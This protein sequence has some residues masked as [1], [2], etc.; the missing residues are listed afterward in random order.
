MA[1]LI[2]FC[3]YSGPWHI[4]NPTIIQGYSL[5]QPYDLRELKDFASLTPCSKPEVEASG[6]DLDAGEHLR[7]LIVLTWGIALDN[8]V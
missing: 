3:A 5:A 1:G 4:P 8:G 2:P 6:S 7:L